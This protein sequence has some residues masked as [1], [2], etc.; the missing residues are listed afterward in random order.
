[1]YVNMAF[2]KKLWQRGVCG[3]GGERGGVEE[4]SSVSLP[5]IPYYG[6]VVIGMTLLHARPTSPCMAFIKKRRY[7]ILRLIHPSLSLFVIF[8]HVTSKRIM[9]ESSIVY[10]QLHTL[11]F[12]HY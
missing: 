2:H 10:C 8:L 1:M 12:A 11:V 5:L 4:K 7:P 3:G 6:A 9:P